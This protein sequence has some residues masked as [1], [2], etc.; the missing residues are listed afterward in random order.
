MLDLLKKF[1]NKKQ[2]DQQ[3]SERDLNGRKHVGY[4]TL[5]LSREID[6]LVKTKYKSIKPIVKMYKETLFF[7]WG[8]S[9]INNTLTDE[10]L[11]KL[12]GR[13]VQMVYLLLFRDMLRHIAAVIKIRYADEDWSE[14]FAQ[15]V[16]DACKMLSDTDDKDIVKKQQLFANTELFTVDTPI[17]DQNPENTEI[18]VWAE[19]IA[20]LIMLPP[21]MI[22]KCHRPLMT[23]ILKKLKKNKK[24]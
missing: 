8:P 16:L 17:D 20:E 3:L 14:Q 6:N 24:K 12:S 11:A 7:K 5:Q 9:V 13:N 23:V 4:P 18:P 10:Q 1:L 21:D 22:Y 15:Q 2:K 19:P